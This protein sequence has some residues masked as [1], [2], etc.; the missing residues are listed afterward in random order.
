MNINRLTDRECR[1]ARKAML[2][3]GG[4]L[5]L[6]TTGDA[7]S[8]LLRYSRGGKSHYLGLGPFPTVSL[9]Q[10][11]ERAAAARRTLSDGKDP[12]A[13]RR[14]AKRTAAM[15]AITF[16]KF[17][18]AHVEAHKAG[19]APEH[20]RQWE[21]SLAKHVYP[22]IGMKPVDEIGLDDVLKVLTPLWNTTTITASRIRHRLE[23]ILDAARA[24]G[25]REGP[26]P[27]TWRGNL[28][29]LLPAP[30]KVAPVVHY[31]ALPWREALGL[32]AA[33][34]QDE[35]VEAAALR[36]AILTAARTGEVLGAR[37]AEIDL[38][39]RIWTLP[40]ERTKQRRAHRVPLTDAAIEIVKAMADICMGDFVFP[41]RRGPMSH[42]MLRAALRRATSLDVT[43][44]AMRSTFRVW[45]AE[46]TSFPGELAEQA[47]GHSVGSEVERAYQRSD[48]F[49]RRRALMAAWAD[50]CGSRA[51]VVLLRSGER[52]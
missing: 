31:A 23:G 34:K 42:P 11:R 12:I 13:E 52:A 3:D 1:N 45:V 14:T 8:W 50:V 48:Q 46:A 19:W 26:N 37:W 18:R 22:V 20:H 5:Y 9:A 41:G 44:H 29:S 17:A 7:Q 33:L 28:K 36:F 25:L 30:R 51:N 43:V 39:Q 47:L 27:A 49:E 6:Q 2:C 24:R 10:A 15:K 40:P 35:S 21:W 16:E 38:D 4:G 32:M